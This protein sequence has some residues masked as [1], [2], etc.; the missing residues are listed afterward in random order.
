LDKRSKILKDAVS[1]K[2]DIK[3]S[4]IWARTEILAGYGYK[5]NPNGKSTLD[6]VIF[7]GSNIVPLGGV[8]F[9]FS[10]LFGVDDD[11]TVP[12]LYS[13]K[14]I[15]IP[16]SP[17]PTE[18]Y[19]S[20]D[21]E[22]DSTGNRVRHVKYRYGHIVQLFGVGITGTSENDISIY[23]PDYREN[24]IEIDKTISDLGEVTGQMIPFRFTGED[25]TT[26][27]AMK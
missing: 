27:E 14:G 18:T 6:E 12:T 1:F 2:D 8:S 26:A 3:N 11:I 17:K 20:P 4:G 13:Q 9:V 19:Y 24:T 21:G 5:N 7:T 22:E 25:L 10:D 16:D 15:G 23:K